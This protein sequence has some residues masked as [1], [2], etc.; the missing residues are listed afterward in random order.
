MSPIFTNLYTKTFESPPSIS[1]LQAAAQ[2][3]TPVHIELLPRSIVM[4]MENNDWTVNSDDLYDLNCSAQGKVVELKSK[5][6]LTE[7]Y[8]MNSVPMSFKDVYALRSMRT[9]QMV[10][11]RKQKGRGSG[12]SSY[13]S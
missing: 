9:G 4:Q 3:S 7:F 13:P 2:I 10:R 11:T 8:M 5:D 1:Y 6:R 12:E